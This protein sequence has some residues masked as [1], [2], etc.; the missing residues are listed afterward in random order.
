MRKT[1]KFEFTSESDDRLCALLAAQQALVEAFAGFD[2]EGDYCIQTVDGQK[3]Q[4]WW[5]MTVTEEE[6]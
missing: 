3:C 1:Y 5:K 2:E 6:K 4:S